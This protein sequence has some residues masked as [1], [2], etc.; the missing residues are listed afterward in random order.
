M[1]YHS[2][3]L[4]APPAGARAPRAPRAHHARTTQ[5]ART[6]RARR[7]HAAR[8]PR[9]PHAVSRVYH[10]C[11]TLSQSLSRK[12]QPKPSAEALS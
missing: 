8:T 3:K 1:E 6:P 11:G 10:V 2:G 9:A 4:F 12:P 5:A 7:A